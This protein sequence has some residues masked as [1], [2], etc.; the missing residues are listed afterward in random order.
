MAGSDHLD[1]P[2]RPRLFYFAGPGGGIGPTRCRATTVGAARA[3]PG[4]WRWRATGAGPVC[5]ARRRCSSRT[6]AAPRRAAAPPA[7]TTARHHPS[8]TG[9]AITDAGCAACSRERGDWRSCGRGHDWRGTGQ[10][11][12]SWRRQ[13]ARCRQRQRSG[14]RWRA[15]SAKAASSPS[16]DHPRGARCAEK[17]STATSRGCLLRLIDRRGEAGV[18]HPNERRRAQSTSAR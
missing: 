6:N 7:Q 11:R 18:G 8:T 13:R 10:W 16:G 3:R 9:A 4:R 2:P 14:Q 15:R 17:C 1:R 12:R 5:A